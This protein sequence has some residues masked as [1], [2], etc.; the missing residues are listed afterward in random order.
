MIV[1]CTYN[2][3]IH[4]WVAHIKYVCNIYICSFFSV[5]RVFLFVA[6]D[7]QLL[8]CVA[9]PI[10]LLPRSLARSLANALSVL[11]LSIFHLSLVML[12]KLYVEENEN[13]FISFPVFLPSDCTCYMHNLAA[14]MTDTNNC[15]LCFLSIYSHA[16]THWM[17]WTDMQNFNFVDRPVVY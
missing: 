7:F 17:M 3:F 2:L 9:S 15:I 1:Q 10:H 14:R 6:C 12:R 13:V 8:P 5:I 11:C 16:R 4:L